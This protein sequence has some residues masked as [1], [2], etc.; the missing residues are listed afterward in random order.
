MIF[1]SALDDLIL[2]I[3]DEILRGRIQKELA[4]LKRTKDVGLVFENHNPECTPLYNVPVKVNSL[5]AL[6]A[7]KLN[8][9]FRVIAID[10]DK[11][12]CIR[13]NQNFT[14]NLNELATVAQFGDPI[15]PYLQPIDAVC[16][17][18]DSKLWHALIEAENY[19]ALQLLKYL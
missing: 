7:G 5:V 9:M 16:N 10:N 12:S 11:V 6:K 3:P 14:F 17:A 18:P 19:H 13:D 8:E 2:Q 15:Y 1:I 4:E